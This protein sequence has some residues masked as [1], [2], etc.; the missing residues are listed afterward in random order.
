MNCNRFSLW[1]NKFHISKRVQLSLC[2]V[3]MFL[4]QP[5]IIVKLKQVRFFK[6]RQLSEKRI[7]ILYLSLKIV[8]HRY[9][10]KDICT[11]LGDFAAES[12]PARNLTLQMLTSDFFYFTS[13]SEI[14]LSDP[15]KK[16]FCLDTHRHAI[17]IY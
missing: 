16:K 12:F 14:S 10:N 2:N 17:V 15:S 9:A 8:L 7:L 6:L 5:Y 4:Y 11:I 1:R 3:T 13:T